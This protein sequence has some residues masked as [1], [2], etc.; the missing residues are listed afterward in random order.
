M[1]QF[2][3]EVAPQG[4][5][6]LATGHSPPLII[7]PASGHPESPSHPLM[8][9]GSFISSSSPPLPSFSLFSVPDVGN[10]CFRKAA[11]LDIK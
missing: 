10:T 6:E 3:E 2:P 1:C 7:L 5:I 9:N 11:G 8:S 4:L